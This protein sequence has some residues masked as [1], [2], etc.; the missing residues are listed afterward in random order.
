MLTK[1]KENIKKKKEKNEWKGG[2]S[3]LKR[4]Y[5]NPYYVEIVSASRLRYPLLFPELYLP[6]L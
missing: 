2:E 5:K 3:S 4:G 1:K 6:Q